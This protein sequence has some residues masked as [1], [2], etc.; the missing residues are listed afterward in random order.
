MK[1]WTASMA[2]VLLGTAAIVPAW[3]A[4]GAKAGDGKAVFTE[5]KCNKCHR[6][7]TENIAPLK[8]KDDIVD[9]SGVGGDHD[10]AWFKKWLLKEVEKD[11]KLKP[12]EK[13]KHKGSWKGTDA[14]L[15]TVTAW[16]KGLT[17]KA[18]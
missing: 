10:A 1:S 8:E 12:G 13:V 18:K 16:L 11:S 4:D 14:E 6:V 9:I 15:D 3:A 17:K 7:T 5:Q 2:M